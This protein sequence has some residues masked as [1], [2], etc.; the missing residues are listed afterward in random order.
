M[1]KL[2]AFLAAIAAF[3]LL[4]LVSFFSWG[5]VAYKF[6]YWFMLPV[7]PA[8]PS[9]T[10]IQAIGLLFFVGVITHKS[11]YVEPNWLKEKRVQKEKIEALAMSLLGPFITL[12]I[13]YLMYII[14]F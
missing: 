10:L 2:V 14:F 3:S 12:G 13:G 6:W 9:I 11:K 8:L 1:I 7:F 5:L 4:M